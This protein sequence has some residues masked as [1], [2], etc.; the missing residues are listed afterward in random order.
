V[1]RVRLAEICAATSLFTDLGTGQPREHGLRTCLVAMRIAEAVDP[2]PDLR[3]D[4]FYVS[5]LRFLGCTADA[6]E[7]AAM[8]GGDDV[9]FLAGMA[10]A[11]MG[12]PR[13]E[14]ARLL[15]L[16][17]RGERVPRRLRLLARA[18]SDPSSKA[19]L[20]DAHCEVAVR[21]ASEMGLDRGVTD[22]LAVAYARWDG[23]GIPETV[24]G[25]A[26]P[27][28]MR[29]AIVARDIELWGRETDTT[30]TAEV[31]RARRG[32]A[33]APEVVDAALS[34]GVDELRR[35]DGDPWEFLLASEPKPWREV[36]GS[37]VRLTLATLGDFADLKAPEFA[38]HSRRVER[39]A[40][41]AAAAAQLSDEPVEILLRAALVHDLG[42]VAVPAGVWRAPRRL[43]PA[44]WEQVRIHP[45]W[46][47]RIVARCSGLGPVA[48]VAGR[49][50]E[51]F[52]GSGY[53]AGIRGDDADPVVGLLACV[54]LFDE[55]T[56]PRPY[57]ARHS[58][59]DAAAELIRLAD[60][61]ALAR[62]AVDA[63]LEATDQAARQTRTER[64][65]G[66]LTERE[67]DV[68]R[69]LSHGNTNRQIA[70]T[71]DISVK[72]VGA[73]VEHIYVKAGVRSRAAATLY[74]MQNQL[75]S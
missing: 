57:R 61:G 44:E 31:L 20:L 55:R 8:V 43:D 2:G 62:G 51:R 7:T 29:V 10:P 25:E 54:D 49:H 52:D 18:L 36:T 58:D 17:G 28:S 67:V 68:L 1:D 6:H 60:D 48:R 47:E 39:L 41:E 71:L 13:E 37:D 66:G 35:V 11:T 23:R 14:I 53:P 4:V 32:R 34:I 3:T 59:A 16:V 40:A 30:T 5:L 38:G 72:T 9:G 15:G 22:S 42:V 69:L 56:S 74:A 50:H 26:I 73:H 63:V 46:S 33:Y 45:M 27:M 70:A 21:L 64:R 65:P 24:A 75:L 12:S 19:R